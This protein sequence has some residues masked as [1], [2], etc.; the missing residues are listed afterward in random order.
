[1]GNQSIKTGTLASD[2]HFQ[3]FEQL[4]VTNQKTILRL[5]LR[6]RNYGQWYLVSA[7]PTPL[8]SV[9]FP[10]NTQLRIQNDGIK[11]HCCLSYFINNELYQIHISENMIKELPFNFE[12]KDVLLEVYNKAKESCSNEEHD[13]ILEKLIDDCVGYL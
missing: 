1:M 11:I 9:S 5:L 3:N 12:S 13:S 10:N 8:Y 7:Y 4:S 6:L 2:N